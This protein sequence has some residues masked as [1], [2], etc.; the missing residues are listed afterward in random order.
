MRSA[1]GDAEVRK[2]EET[3]NQNRDE[4]LNMLHAHD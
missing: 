2:K 1:P 3:G 4:Y